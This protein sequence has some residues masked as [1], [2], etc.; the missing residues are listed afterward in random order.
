L[1]AEP[2]SS[3]LYI[4]LVCFPTITS[5]ALA[6]PLEYP[7]SPCFARGATKSPSGLFRAPPCFWIDSCVLPSSSFGSFRYALSLFDNTLYPLR[8]ISS[9]L[10]P[11]TGRDET[12]SDKGDDEATSAKFEIIGAPH[13]FITYSI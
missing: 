7:Q 2:S 8:T 12:S 9:G 13:R 6:R 11:N 5:V 3:G 4:M 10:I 1:L